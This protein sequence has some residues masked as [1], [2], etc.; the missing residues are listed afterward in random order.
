MT[1]VLPKKGHTQSYMPS[2]S[3]AVRRDGVHTSSMA[4]REVPGL[5]TTPALAPRSLICTSRHEAHAIAHS[6]REF[7]RSL[8]VIDLDSWRLHTG[9]SRVIILGA[10]ECIRPRVWDSC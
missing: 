8:E 1:S 7:L 6:Q 10:L 5:R 4:V 9:A 3:K 2:P